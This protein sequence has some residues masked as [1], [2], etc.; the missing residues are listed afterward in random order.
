MKLTKLDIFRY[1]KS[2]EPKIKKEL[3][4]KVIIR[5]TFEKEKTILRRHP[6]T[7]RYITI[8]KEREDVDDPKSFS[9]W[10][11][12]RATEFHKVFGPKTK[13]L[14]IDID[15]GKGVPFK[16]TKELTK[17]LVDYIKD[18]LNIRPKIQ[19]SGG[20]GFYLI[21]PL[22]EEI[23][24]NKGRKLLKEFL[25]PICE[26]NP[27]F[28]LRPAKKNQVRLD[29]TILKNKGSYR[30]PYS[31]NAKT[32]LVSLFVPYEK[33]LSFVPERDANPKNFIK[34]EAIPERLL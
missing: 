12:R 7:K 17:I 30:A 21:L 13:E 11:E 8:D 26:E 9:Y 3:T 34:K 33:L 2:I 23:S 5:Q 1:Y 14:V 31:L 4:E 32:G 28:T 16:K 18:S 25:E 29:I 19:Y 27:V 15:P 6:G 24:V 20:K 22:K 10:I